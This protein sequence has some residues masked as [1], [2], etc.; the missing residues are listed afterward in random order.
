MQKPFIAV[1]G[2]SRFVGV[3]T[4]NQNQFILHPVLNFGQAVNVIA[5]GICPV[6]GTRSDDNEEFIAFS[7]KYIPDFRIFYRLDCGQFRRQRKLFLYLVRC[8]Q[9][10]DIFKSHGF[11]LLQIVSYS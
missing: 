2:G 7:R 4:G 1:A 6:G 5:Y 3:N 11:L 10:A 9:F 8:R